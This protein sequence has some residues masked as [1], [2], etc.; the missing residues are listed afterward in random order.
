[1]QLT[2]S[3]EERKLMR[4][5]AKNCLGENFPL[6]REYEDLIGGEATQTLKRTPHRGG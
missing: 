3:E 4:Q 2:W 5:M 1:M 6:G